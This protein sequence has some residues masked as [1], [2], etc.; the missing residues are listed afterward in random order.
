MLLPTT[1]DLY[2]PLLRGLEREG[3][4]FTETGG[5]TDGLAP[6]LD[7]PCASCAGLFE[8]HGFP[9]AFARG[10]AVRRHSIRWWPWPRRRKRSPWTGGPFG[11][12]VAIAEVGPVHQQEVVDVLLVRWLQAHPDIRW[13][14]MAE[15]EWMLRTDGAFY[16]RIK[17]EAGRP[18]LEDEHGSAG[19]G[20]AGPLTPKRHPDGV[21][22]CVPREKVG[23]AKVKGPPFGSPFS[24]HLPHGCRTRPSSGGIAPVS[25]R[26][27]SHACLMA[28]VNS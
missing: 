10:L 22:L 13:L 28:V 4:Q 26:I 12:C 27:R 25:G 2:A 15:T 9:V 14:S 11:L 20:D 7:G 23:N 19:R 1:P 3:V 21:T 5:P 16:L 8:R 24:P 17:A 18:M 6:V